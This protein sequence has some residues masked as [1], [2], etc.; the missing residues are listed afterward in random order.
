MPESLEFFNGE[1][2]T[3]YLVNYQHL[4]EQNLEQEGQIPQTEL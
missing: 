4:Q 2:Y 3:P 1:Q